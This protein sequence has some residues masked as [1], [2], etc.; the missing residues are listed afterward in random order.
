M[1]TGVEKNLIIASSCILQK[2]KARILVQGA[3]CL[4]LLDV[5]SQ[6]LR[7]QALILFQVSGLN[8]ERT[9]ACIVYKITLSA[10][11]LYINLFI[12]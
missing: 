6:P 3:V 1:V 2:E 4:L 11:H 8:V 5:F 10:V 7:H 9:F 12:E